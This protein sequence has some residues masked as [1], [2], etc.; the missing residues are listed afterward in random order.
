MGEARVKAGPRSEGNSAQVRRRQCGESDP[1]MRPQLRCGPAPLCRAARVGAEGT[2]PSLRA[3]SRHTPVLAEEERERKKG[4]AATAAAA[5]AMA[6]AVPRAGSCSL[7]CSVVL[8]VCWEESWDPG[9]SAG[10]PS[11]AAPPTPEDPPRAA[12]RACNEARPATRHL[13]RKH[14]FIGSSW[15]ERPRCVAPAKR[16]HAQCPPLHR[17]PPACSRYR[18]SASSAA[19]ICSSSEPYCPSSSSKWRGRSEPVAARVTWRRP[20]P[21]L[22]PARRPPVLPGWACTGVARLAVRGLAAPLP[23][24]ASFDRC[25]LRSTS[26]SSSPSSSASLPPSEAAYRARTP[27]R[28]LPLPRGASTAAASSSSS[29][30]SASSSASSSSSLS[31][32]RFRARPARARRRLLAASSGPR[33]GSRFFRCPAAEVHG[34]SRGQRSSEQRGHRRAARIGE[35]RPQSACAGV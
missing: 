8:R 4:G 6:A 18:S 20:A 5:A 15:A 31:A 23:V 1:G 13:A 28:A 7:Q 22:P 24:R 21:P 3:P 12:C 10:A 32:L 34:S 26:S 25:R 29:A 19:S 35:P 11:R 30:I 27:R 14:T 16:M 33:L 2:P 17:P 9:R